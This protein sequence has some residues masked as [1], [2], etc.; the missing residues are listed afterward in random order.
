MQ[1]FRF[2]SLNRK[3]HYSVNDSNKYFPRYKNHSFFS[4]FMTPKKCAPIIKCVCFETSCD[5]VNYVFSD[6]SL[7]VLHA[8]RK[9]EIFLMDNAKKSICL[10]ISFKWKSVKKSTLNCAKMILLCHIECQH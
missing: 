3:R 5:N 2:R 4:L 7:I 8:F 6:F 10:S 9:L 1:F